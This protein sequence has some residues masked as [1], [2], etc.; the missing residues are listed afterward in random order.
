MG[1]A[2]GDA[3]KASTTSHTVRQ[4]FLPDFSVSASFTANVAIIC[5][6]TAEGLPSSSRTAC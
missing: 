1:T 5:E 6:A 3:N 2:I 4:F